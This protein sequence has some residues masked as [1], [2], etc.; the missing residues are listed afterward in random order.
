VA[1]C[2]SPDRLAPKSCTVC[3]VW[4]LTNLLPLTAMP[5]VLPVVPPDELLEL[6]LEELVLEELLEEELDELLLLLAEGGALDV[7]PELLLDDESDPPHAVSTADES[8]SI[9]RIICRYEGI[10]RLRAE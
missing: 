10:N 1:P 8:A 6:A 9:G 5:N 7:A 4:V 2:S 3:P